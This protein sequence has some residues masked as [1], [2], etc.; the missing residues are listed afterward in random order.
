VAERLKY[1]GELPELTRF[2]FTEPIEA[3]VKSLYLQ[4][5]DKYLKNSNPE[6]FIK[7]LKEVYSELEE[8]D[9][10]EEDVKNRLNSLLQ[11]L[12][13]RPG[14]LFSVVR[15]AVTGS[16]ASPEIFGTLRVLGKEKSMQRLRQAVL[17]LEK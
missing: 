7:L 8:S 12:D 4:P 1:L 2:F 10:S 6:D 15:I 13:T 11:K 9:F 14:I 3:D 16:K 5:Q 17:T